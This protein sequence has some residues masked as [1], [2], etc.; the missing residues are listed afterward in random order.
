MRLASFFVIMGTTQ[1]G[2]PPAASQKTCSP[3]T[4]E[5]KLGYESCKKTNQ[6]LHATVTAVR[7][8]EESTLKMYRQLTTEHNELQQNCAKP[9]I[10]GK[11]CAVEAETNRLN[12]LR[13]MSEKSQYLERL[14]L[15]I[16]RSEQAR[17]DDPAV[18]E[19]YVDEA[20]QMAARL[21][22]AKTGHAVPVSTRDKISTKFYSLVS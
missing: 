10:G 22:E 11:L 14:A 18:K 3:Y 7:Q 4:S 2:C 19:K 16:P 17:C 8:G 1:S 15:S 9:I 5:F 12:Y 6:G 21:W 13:C 20:W